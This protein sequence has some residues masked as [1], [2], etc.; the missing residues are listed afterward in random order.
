MTQFVK[1]VAA[2]MLFACMSVAA[3]TSRAITG[4][5][6]SSQ[7]MSKDPLTLTGAL[8]RYVDALIRS[9]RQ[10]VS[11]YSARFVFDAS[12]VESIGHKQNKNGFL[13]N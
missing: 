4:C 11:T 3:Q 5:K 6:A 1:I 13:I 7:E 2:T 10:L 9:D 12:G 8:Q